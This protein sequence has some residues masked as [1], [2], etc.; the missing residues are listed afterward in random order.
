MRH[1][2]KVLSVPITW[3]YNLQADGQIIG[4]RRA[5][6]SYIALFQAIMLNKQHNHGAWEPQILQ[7]QLLRKLFQPSRLSPK[8][9]TTFIGRLWRPQNHDIEIAQILLRR[10]CTDAWSWRNTSQIATL[11]RE[12]LSPSTSTNRQPVSQCTDKFTP[13]FLQGG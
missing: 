8:E 13:N 11:Q 10:W 4:F 7:I 6:Q 12:N 2:L 1:V 9:S 3:V 5:Q